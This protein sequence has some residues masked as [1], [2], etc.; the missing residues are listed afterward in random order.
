MNIFQKEIIKIIKISFQKKY[1]YL[2]DNF[3]IFFYNKMEQ[4]KKQNS[5]TSQS[6]SHP[7]ILSFQKTFSNINGKTNFSSKKVISDGYTGKIYLDNNGQVTTSDL[8]F[9]QLKKEFN[10][11]SLNF[12]SPKMF[13]QH[14]LLFND[15]K[16]YKPKIG[17]RQPF[18]SKQFNWNTF[19]LLMIFFLLIFISIKLVLGK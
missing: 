19:L 1:K 5:L 15:Y 13:N 18:F 2:S 16:I 6:M 4:L 12:D 7:N 8:N 10:F 9:N 14:P 17:R 11:P 3:N